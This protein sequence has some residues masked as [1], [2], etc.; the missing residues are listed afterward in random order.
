MVGRWHIDDDDIIIETSYDAQ[1]N[2]G[3]KATANV[4][5]FF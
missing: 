5:G 4:V 2:G 1:S 3:C